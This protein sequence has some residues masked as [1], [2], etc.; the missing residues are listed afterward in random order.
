M[1]SGQSLAPHVSLQN[2]SP[3]W[4]VWLHEVTVVVLDSVVD[5]LV[6]VV[7][8]VVCVTVVTDEDVS[9]VVLTVLVDIV[10][11]PVVVSV[12][13]EL[14]WQKPQVVSHRCAWLHVGQKTTSQSCWTQSQHARQ[15]SS[16][17]Q[18]VLERVVLSLTVLVV[19]LHEVCVCVV[20]VSVSLE[21]VVVVEPVD[22]VVEMVVTVV[23]VSVVVCVLV[24]EVRVTLVTV[25]VVA[26]VA[27]TVVQSWH[28]RSHIPANSPHVGQKR[29]SQ[30]SSH[31]ALKLW[32]VR[33]QNESGF[34]LIIS[35]DVSEV[36]VTDSVDAVVEMVLM[37]VVVAV[38]VV[39]V[40]VVG[41]VLDA[42]VLPEVTVVVAV[43]EVPSA[44]IWHVV[45]HMWAAGQVGQNTWAQEHSW[46]P[47]MQGTEPLVISGHEGTQSSYMK[48]VVIVVLLVPLAVVTLPVVMVVVLVVVVVTLEV[49]LV[50][51]DRVDC[52]VVP[53]VIVTVVVFVLPVLVLTVM[54]DSV[55]VEVAVDV[56]VYVLQYPHD[57]SQRPA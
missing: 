43:L 13:V 31:G 54:V 33:L 39:I 19:K 53:V 8:S 46:A 26:E 6:T 42:V 5:T 30:G 4:S 37:D 56:F 22:T 25:V 17:W 27:V 34:K 7:V 32:Q 44:Q 47:F 45:S 40:A 51:T 29:V 16:W 52:V 18:V 49:V 57:L 24:S 15:S 9:E 11:V 3:A 1:S 10:D 38:V 55:V 36:P 28:W 21:T 35:Q 50:L 20:V 23:E 41:V 14:S 48:Q 12:V 2:C